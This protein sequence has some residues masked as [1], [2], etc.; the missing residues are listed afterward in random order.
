MVNS[1]SREKREV[2]SGSG[3]R[4]SFA[5]ERAV[6]TCT[7]VKIA[8]IPSQVD[9]AAQGEYCSMPGCQTGGWAGGGGFGLFLCTAHLAPA[10]VLLG[11]NSSIF[12]SGTLGWASTTEWGILSCFS[13]PGILP[14]SSVSLLWLSCT[15]FL[16][17]LLFGI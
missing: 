11:F 17:C 14:V 13:I 3:D 7:M 9:V 10:D 5:L 4:R 6:C 12:G 16:I 15:G 2:G 8:R 1:V